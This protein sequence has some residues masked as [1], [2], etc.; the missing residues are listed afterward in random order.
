MKNWLAALALLCAA[1]VAHSQPTTY[2]A[3]AAGN[4]TLLT[5]F[6]APCN[7]GPCQNFNTGIGASGSFTTAAPLAAN[8]VAAN[9]TAL[10][11]A[12]SFSDGI[13]TYASTNPAVRVFLFNI[14]TNAA[15][16]ITASDVRVQ[17][18][19]TGAAVHVAGDRHSMLEIRATSEVDYNAPC[20][21]VGVSPAGVADSCTVIG[22]DT[23]RSLAFGSARVWA[24]AAAATAALSVPTLS[25]W[26]LIL[27]AGL[28]GLAALATLR[29]GVRPR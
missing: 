7:T 14:S 10:V 22:N 9:I 6:T 21:T 15:G 2:V 23:S 26:G 3:T 11:T 29:R 27:M 16:A 17:R 12:F 28:V 19:L 1:T 8:L 25:E 24:I 20:L 5:N 4:Y 13:H 18:W